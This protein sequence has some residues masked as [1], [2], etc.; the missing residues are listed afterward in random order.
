MDGGV[1]AGDLRVAERE[2]V[3][4]VTTDGEGERI[5]RDGGGGVTVVDDEARGKCCCIHG[6]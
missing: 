3:V 4:G 6:F 5:E 2:V 1:L